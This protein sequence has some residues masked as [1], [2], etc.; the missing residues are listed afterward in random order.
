MDMPDSPQLHDE[1]LI[2]TLF[3]R[4]R[5]QLRALLLDDEPWFVLNDLARLINRVPLDERAPRN[6]DPDQLQPAWVRDSRGEYQRELLVSDCGVYALLIFYYHP[7]NGSIRR[8]ISREVI[9]RLREERHPNALRPYR[10]VL[11]WQERPLEVLHW[12]GRTWLDASE[13]HRLLQ[14]PA[15]VIG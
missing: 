14:R 7:E 13:C 12:Q 6:L 4:H 5:R 9:P 15:R 1:I 8:W 3:T 10:D 2:P 11:H